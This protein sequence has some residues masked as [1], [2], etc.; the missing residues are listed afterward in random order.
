VTY[1]GEWKSGVKN[2]PGEEINI[3]TNEKYSGEYKDG[4]KDG[5]G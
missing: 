4:I 5:K 2:G 3:I 1:I